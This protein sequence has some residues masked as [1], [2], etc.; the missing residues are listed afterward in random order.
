MVMT[1][2]KL[3]VI[4][5]D[6]SILFSALLGIA[7]LSWAYTIY[8][9]SLMPDM[10]SAQM[11]MPDFR[12]W[13]LADLGFNFLMWTVMMV[14]MMTPTAIPVVLT[15]A[16][17]A[18]QRNTAHSPLRTA[19]IFLAGYLI[20]WV[21]FSFAATCFQ[22]GLHSAL[23]LPDHMIAVTPALGALLLILAGLYQFT[24][25]KLACLSRCRTPLGFVTDEWRE[26][27]GGALIMGLKHGAY[28]AGC[29]W[30]L[31]L[32]LFVVG[33]M[34]LYWVILIAILV[35]VEKAISAGQWL[36]RAA[37]LLT[38]LWGLAMFVSLN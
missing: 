31:M 34:N 25:L 8:L 11:T 32:L 18:R 30:L 7:L 2:S 22:W 1:V 24:P 33:V 3:R 27:N 4:R 29:C 36:G 19:A 20:I 15:T 16:Y 17:V 35:L 37:G 12:P 26:G 21:V 28:C 23:L 13:L 9:A 5:R 6:R 38:I 14:A 10:G